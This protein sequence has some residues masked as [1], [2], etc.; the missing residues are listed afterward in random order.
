MVW[1]WISR[2]LVLFVAEFCS[3]VLDCCFLPCFLIFSL[4]LDLTSFPWEKHITENYGLSP[5]GEWSG[6]GDLR[7]GT[8]Y[9]TGLELE[10]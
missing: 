7:S 4:V 6:S 10:Y 2:T 8:H 3:F 9:G 1:D 5:T